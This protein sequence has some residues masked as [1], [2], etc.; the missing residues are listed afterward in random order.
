MINTFNWDYWL[1]NEKCPFLT[2]YTKTNFRYI[3]D[4]NVKKK[5]K[6]QEEILEK[7]FLY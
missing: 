1:T 6:L 7:H 5:K 3:K 2:I 4:L